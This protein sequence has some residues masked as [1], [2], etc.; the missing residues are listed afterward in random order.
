[1]FSEGREKLYY[2]INMI[3]AEL[4]E[5]ADLGMLFEFLTGV[6]EKDLFLSILGFIS[7]GRGGGAS[8]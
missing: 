2:F 6:Y 8:T 1:M 3:L 5:F 4:I 7:V